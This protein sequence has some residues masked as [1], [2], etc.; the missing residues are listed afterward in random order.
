MPYLTVPSE[1]TGKTSALR[2]DLDLDTSIHVPFERPFQPRPYKRR[3]FERLDVY[4]FESIKEKR[5]VEVSGVAAIAVVLA[6]ECDPSVQAYGERPRH[7]NYGCDRVELDFWVKHATGFEEFLLIVRDDECIQGTG[8]V[9]RPRDA[10]RLQMAA[11]DQNLA[12]R[13]ITE[14]D[15]RV[16]GSSVS[17]HMRL[18]AFAQVAQK[19]ANRLSLRTR[20]KAHL[21]QVER[22]RIDQLESALATFNP[23]D[24]QAVTCELICLGLVHFDR[25]SRLG[26][27][28]L[29][30]RTAD[31]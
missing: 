29:V 17:Q 3:E 28:T 11:K 4:G 9:P 20:I 13:L 8:G 21:D 30:S 25:A 18:L 6:F 22:A 7:L 31:A 1:R 27:H 15:V 10:E 26:R 14:H 12:L 2:P 24:V 5:A 23:H 19:L 16:Q